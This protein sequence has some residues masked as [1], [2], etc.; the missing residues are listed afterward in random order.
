MWSHFSP[1]LVLFGARRDKA[2]DLEIGNFNWKSTYKKQFGNPLY[3]KAEKQESRMLLVSYT[4][5]CEIRLS[6]KSIKLSLLFLLTCGDSCY[7][8]FMNTI[9]GNVNA[10]S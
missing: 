7:M 8:H 4:M 3:T 6:I 9:N 10:E 2:V 5:E 1:L